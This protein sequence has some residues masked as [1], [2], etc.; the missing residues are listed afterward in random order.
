MRNVEFSYFY[1]CTVLIIEEKFLFQENSIKK[2]VQIKNEL[3]YL[4]CLYIIKLHDI[5]GM[6]SSVHIVFNMYVLKVY[7][8]LC[9]KEGDKRYK[10]LIESQIN[11]NIKCKIW[12]KQNSLI[13]GSCEA[14]QRISEPFDYLGCNIQKFISW[15]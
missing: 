12:K 5:F 14:S 1:E 2:H 6:Y 13:T 7:E 15:Q 8:T 9:S 10:W 4:K 3:K 11:F